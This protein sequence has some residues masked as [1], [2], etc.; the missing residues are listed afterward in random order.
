MVG[1][2]WFL[3]GGLGVCREAALEDGAQL[4]A[5]ISG[6]FAGAAASLVAPRSQGQICPL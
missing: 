4:R 3:G 5:G 1:Q 6:G 2:A